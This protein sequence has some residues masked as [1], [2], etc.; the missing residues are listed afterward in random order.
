MNTATGT[1]RTVES[2]SAPHT[3]ASDNTQVQELARR[4]QELCHIAEELLNHL[5]KLTI[6][7]EVM[8]TTL[9]SAITNTSMSPKEKEV[10]KGIIQRV[11]PTGIKSLLDSIQLTTQRTR[12]LYVESYQ[13]A[14][15]QL[16]KTIYQQSGHGGP[17]GERTFNNRAEGKHAA[18]LEVATPSK[19][20]TPIP[21]PDATARYRAL[22]KSHPQ[23]AAV[24]DKVA[25]P[26]VTALQEWLAACGY[27]QKDTAS[28]KA[29]LNYGLD[30]VIWP[31]NNTVVSVEKLPH[32]S[33]G[34]VYILKLEKPTNG[35]ETDHL[36]LSDCKVWAPTQYPQHVVVEMSARASKTSPFANPREKWE[37]IVTY[38]DKQYHEQNNGTSNSPSPVRNTIH[39][40]KTPQ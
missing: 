30:A 37:P 3:V 12:H 7:L 39:H 24:L 9:C 1:T 18:A 27:I 38:L 14:A 4:E 17:T 10:A 36:T 33:C 13:L 19:R 6:T 2:T 26:P 16:V 5:S 20:V 11:A 34:T 40:H 15:E 35:T 25:K 23:L 22:T 28:A 21:T 8:Q 31:N 32:P 29:S